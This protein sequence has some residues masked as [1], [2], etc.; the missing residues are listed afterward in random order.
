MRSARTAMGSVLGMVAGL[1]LALGATTFSLPSRRRTVVRH[2]GYRVRVAGCKLAKQAAN[3][4][5]GMGH[6]R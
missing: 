1:G 5:L 2:R 6:P 4:R 3:G